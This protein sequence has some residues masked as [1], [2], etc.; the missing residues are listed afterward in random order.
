MYQQT[1]EIN[2]AA[3]KRYPHFGGAAEAEALNI[4]AVLARTLIRSH[5][6]RWTNNKKLFSEITYQIDKRPPV[7]PRP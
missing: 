4:E 2:E 6:T 5:D 7:N 3:Y 1:H